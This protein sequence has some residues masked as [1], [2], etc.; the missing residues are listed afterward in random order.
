MDYRT[1]ASWVEAEPFAPFRIVMTDG[2]AFDIRHPNM[3]WPGRRSV[4]VGI[5]DDPQE[6]GVYGAHVS[7]ALIHVVRIEPLNP[8]VP[9]GP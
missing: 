5:P 4:M 3:A 7:V 1:I 8:P 2:R 9:A 6:P